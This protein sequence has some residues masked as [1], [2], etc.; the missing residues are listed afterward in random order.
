MKHTKTI[1]FAIC[2]L[3]NLFLIAHTDE[4]SH[5]SIFYEIKKDDCIKGYI[6]GTLHTSDGYN[7][8]ASKAETLKPYL[9]NVKKIY[10]ETKEVPFYK[11]LTAEKAI[12]QLLKSNEVTIEELETE[13][14]Q[15]SFLT[16]KYWNQKE[17]HLRFNYQDLKNKSHTYFIYNLLLNKIFNIKNY[18]FN[19]QAIDEKSD[20]ISQQY[21]QDY[22]N[23]MFTKMSK[24]DFMPEYSEEWLF[25]NERNKNWIEHLLPKLNATHEQCCIAVGAG[26]LPGKEGIINLLKEA[27]YTC[28]PITINPHEMS[29]KLILEYIQLMQ[30]KFPSQREMLEKMITE[31]TYFE[32]WIDQLQ[33]QDLFEDFLHLINEQ[34]QTIFMKATCSGNI[35]IVRKLLEKNQPINQS[36]S[37]PIINHPTQKSI[38]VSPLIGS[39]M[40]HQRIMTEYLICKGASIDI[41]Q[42]IFDTTTIEDWIFTHS[43][44]TM[45]NL[46]LTKKIIDPETQLNIQIPHITGEIKIQS[47]PLFLAVIN[48]QPYKIEVLLKHGANPNIPVEHTALYNKDSLLSIAIN[49]GYFLIAL[50]LL[51]AG[52]SASL[53]D[54][55]NIINYPEQKDIILQMLKNT[56]LKQCITPRKKTMLPL[57]LGVPIISLIYISLKKNHIP[58]GV[59]GILTPLILHALVWR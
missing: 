13:I 48:N 58:E 1:L 28:N 10:F 7:I 31:D 40:H 44:H 30:N 47:T 11:N 52:A 8:I 20:L 15:Y 9:K 54:I 57:T 14:F 22:Q 55:K 16:R 51:N 29:K 35:P 27:G 32:N 18:F 36:S 59:V 12:L 37:I 45:L 19:D 46:L 2:L 21:L 23:E 25:I 50:H 49:Q 43:D 6:I 26:H 17:F 39:I 34:N 56:I 42:K 33:N 53:Q 38:F 3:F 5:L 4:H 41:K 24:Y